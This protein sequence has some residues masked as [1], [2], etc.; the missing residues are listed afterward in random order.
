MTETMPER[1]RKIRPADAPIPAAELLEPEWV[2]PEFRTSI[3]CECGEVRTVKATAHP[4][5]AQTWEGNSPEHIRRMQDGE[6]RT[7][8]EKAAREHWKLQKPWERCL[9]LL[10]CKVCDRVTN[11]AFLRN[12]PHRDFAEMEDA[13]QDR[14]VRDWLDKFRKEG[15]RVRSASDK[16][17]A[18]GR[19]TCVWIYQYLDDGAWFLEVGDT[20]L[21]ADRLRYLENAWNLY[22]DQEEKRWYV[23]K[24]T[25]DLR[26][27]RTVC[28]WVRAS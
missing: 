15:F 21:V 17:D 14:A 4:R 12:D 18:D 10:K 25:D 6:H 23:W 9:E 1:G 7:K 20:T 5:G 22:R 28:W 24:K 13:T 27:G 2:E 16:A 11:H 26:P 8:S 19:I 3:C